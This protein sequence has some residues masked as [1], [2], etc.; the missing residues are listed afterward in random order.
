MTKIDKSEFLKSP[1]DFRSNKKDDIEQYIESELEK[2]QDK[3]KESYMDIWFG[4][5]RGGAGNKLFTSW[6]NL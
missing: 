3:N 1:I 2:L 6:E 5:I 4:G